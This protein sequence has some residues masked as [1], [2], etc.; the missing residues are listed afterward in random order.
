MQSQI[1]VKYKLKCDTP[2]FALKAKLHADHGYYIYS[3][4]YAGPPVHARLSMLIADSWSLYNKLAMVHLK[5]QT[6]L[7]LLRES[8]K[9]TPPI[10]QGSFKLP[11]PYILWDSL[12]YLL[13]LYYRKV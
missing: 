6:I 12:S 13:S 4:K 8:F 11:I 2:P 1:V 5:H 9:S 7:Y 3:A 10:L